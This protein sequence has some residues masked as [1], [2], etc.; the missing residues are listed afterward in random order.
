MTVY[1]QAKVYDVC[2]V[3]SGARGGMAAYM[4]TEAGAVGLQAQE[5]GRPRRR[6]ADFL[7]RRRAL[8]RQDRSADWDLRQQGEP[9]QRAERGVPAAAT[10]PLPRAARQAG[11]RPPARHLHSGTPL[12]P[13]AAAERTGGV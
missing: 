10:P 8:L 5:P 11:G 7:R 12:D 1:R 4:L 9:P 3:G 6:L 13:H 2:I